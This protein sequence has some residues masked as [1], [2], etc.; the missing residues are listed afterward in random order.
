MPDPLT[1]DWVHEYEHNTQFIAAAR[2]LLPR[3]LADLDRAAESETV[4]VVALRTVAHAAN[5]PVE[6]RMNEIFH[7]ARTALAS[8]G[9]TT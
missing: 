4:A 3:A 7:I 9:V 1:E 2:T 8:M 5:D 6:D